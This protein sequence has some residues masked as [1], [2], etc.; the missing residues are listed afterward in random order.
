MLEDEVISG[1]ILEMA[2][3]EE[4]TI[5]MALCLFVTLCQIVLHLSIILEVDHQRLAMKHLACL[6]DNLGSS[7]LIGI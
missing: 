4:S 7:V 5:A 3:G 2:I 6:L 1:M